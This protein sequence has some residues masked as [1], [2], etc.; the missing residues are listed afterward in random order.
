[1]GIL[2]TLID[3][4]KVGGWVRAAVTAVLTMI[5]AKLTLKVPFLAQIVTP[6]MVDAVA[7][8]AGTFIA[9]LLSQ[10]SKSA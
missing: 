1:M 8:A 6:D 3:P 7:V 9:G 2:S 10:K 4:G 5:V